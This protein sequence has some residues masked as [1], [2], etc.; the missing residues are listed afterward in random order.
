MA[1]QSQ[2][3]VMRTLALRLAEPEVPQA[4]KKD[5]TKPLARAIEGGGAAIEARE[6]AFADAGRT[7]ARI[8]SFREDANHVLLG[9]EGSLKQIA[10]KRKLKSD[11][12]DL[13]FPPNDRAKTKSAKPEG[14][15][16]GEPQPE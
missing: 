7:S 14:A 4:L 15:K 6:A 2:L 5:H 13:F 8:A 12:V 11:W 1:L 3:P 10:S 16:P 9:I